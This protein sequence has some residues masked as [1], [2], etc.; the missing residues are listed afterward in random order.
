MKQAVRTIFVLSLVLLGTG[1]IGAADAID[2][3]FVSSTPVGSWQ[4]RE[5]VTENAGKTTV[6]VIKTK[7]LGD[8]ERGGEVYAWVES[9]ITN[10]K[11]KKS[12]RKPM[13]KPVYV[14]VLLKKSVLEGDVVNS[15][16]NFS[17]LATEVIMQTGSDQPMRIKNAGQM[18]G[19]FAQAMGLQI[20][21]QLSR[22]GSE[23]ATT[24][25]GSFDCARYKGHGTTTIDMMIKKMTVESTTTQ[26]ISNEVPFGV[27]K[28]VSDD[29]V[30]SKPQHSETTL[31]AF[32]RSG[33][34]SMI[35]GE[36]QDAPE[37]PSLGSLLGGGK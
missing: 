17:E 33:A 7:Y 3:D 29:V 35:T 16:G 22:D 32:G 37:V 20:D 26:W 11:V 10:L 23:T 15:I 31:T 34:V 1:I 12:D 25:A 27:V 19:G 18:V 8:E 21:Y 5:Q 6:T 2:F 13:G 30:N 14:K 24:P 9:E 36:P 4:E 28:V